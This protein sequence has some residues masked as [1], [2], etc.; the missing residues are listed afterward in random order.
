VVCTSFSFWADSAD[1]VQKLGHCFRGLYVRVLAKY[2]VPMH[3]HAEVKFCN[4]A[5]HVTLPTRVSVSPS[6]FPI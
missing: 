5:L 6:H 3:A 4:N 1:N 2:L